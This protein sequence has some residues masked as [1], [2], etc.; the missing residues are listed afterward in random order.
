M[1]VRANNECEN[2]KQGGKGKAVLSRE[3]IADGKKV[4]TTKGEFKFYD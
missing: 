2:R 3:E 4:K 1:F